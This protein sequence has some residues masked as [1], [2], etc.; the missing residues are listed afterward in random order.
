[1][2]HWM[3]S[4]LSGTVVLLPKHIQDLICPPLQKIEHKSGAVYSLIEIHSGIDCIIIVEEIVQIPELL[5]DAPEKQV[6]HSFYLNDK[7]GNPVKFDS[8]IY[9]PEL[10]VFLLY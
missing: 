3:N 1:M 2:Q 7:D 6:Y 4:K 5:K 9:C 10:Y 8:E